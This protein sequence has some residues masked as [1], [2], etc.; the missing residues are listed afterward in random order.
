MPSL[1][2]RPVLLN[3]TLAHLNLRTGIRVI[4]CTLGLGGHSREIPER[5]G[6]TGKLLGIDQDQDNLTV[7]QKNL[8]DFGRQVT[9]AHGNFGDLKEIATRHDFN[10]VDAILLDLG[11]SSPHVDDATRGFSFR[12]DGPLDMRFDRSSGDLTAAEV[13]NRFNAQE[14]TTIFRDLGEERYARRI[15]ERIVMERKIKPLKTTFDLVALLPKAPPYVKPHPATRVFQ[16]LRM[17]VNHELEQLDKGLHQA[18]ELLSPGGRIAVI[19]YHSLE[20]RLVKTI[21]KY[22]T[23]NCICPREVPVCQ[24][25]FK[26]KLYLITKKP[27]IPSGIEVSDNPRARSAKLRVAERL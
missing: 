14:L 22:Y 12:Q 20:D 3:E 4:D 24:C 16:A 2:H 7:A 5:I 9:F 18:I 13:V 19:S 8:I 26:K 21:F 25:N 23:Q 6:S 1:S 17:Y 10:S 11:L 27:I 15:A